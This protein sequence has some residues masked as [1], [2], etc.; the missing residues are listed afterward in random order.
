M[1]HQA[2]PPDRTEDEIMILRATASVSDECIPH[3]IDNSS[4]TVAG[5]SIAMANTLDKLEDDA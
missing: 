5:L 3:Q 4:D 2:L 1:Q